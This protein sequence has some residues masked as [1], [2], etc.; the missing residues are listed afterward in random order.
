MRP[1]A[2]HDEIRRAYT[3]RAFVVHPDRLVDAD[4][5]ALA[6][7]EFKMRELNA[8]WEVLRDPTRRAAYDRG[9]VARSAVGAGTRPGVVAPS[10]GPPEG[11]PDLEPEIEHRP[12]VVRRP[13]GRWAR[14]GPVIVVVVLL[15]LVGM[16]GCLASLSGT[17]DPTEVE[18]TDRFP[19]GSCIVIGQDMVVTEAPCS[20][21]GA[22]QVLGREPFPKSC[23][24]GLRAVVLLE[25]DES[26][27]VPG[28]SP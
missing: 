20:R 3:E 28:T 1:T 14:H 18:T 9:S 10:P 4:A 5:E 24:A 19:L 12:T 26:L 2:G 25:R 7:A 17:T 8:A 13:R 21:P 23:P 27:C 6:G 16:V 22:L 15:A 11:V